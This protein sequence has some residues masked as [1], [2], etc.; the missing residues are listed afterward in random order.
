MRKDSMESVSGC[1]EDSEESLTFENLSPFF[2][3]KE[4]MSLDGRWEYR[5]DDHPLRQLK[6]ILREFWEKAKVTTTTDERL[7]LLQDYAAIKIE[8]KYRI[9]RNVRRSKFGKLIKQK[10]FPKRV[11]CFACHDLQTKRQRHHIIQLQ[12]GGDNRKTNIVIVCKNC[13]ADIHPW[14]KQKLHCLRI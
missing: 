13:H 6:L 7:V 11:A 3:E 10:R 2:E 4:V 12:H 8:F 1:S 9:P 5:E 14:L